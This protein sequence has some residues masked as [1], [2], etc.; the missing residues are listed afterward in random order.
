MTVCRACGWLL[1]GVLD[2]VP[3]LLLD[4]RLA[5][6]KDVRFV[7]HGSFQAD[8]TETA[9]VLP[10]NE[11]AVKARTMLV[12]E[13]NAAVRACALISDTFEA[14]LARR[15][16]RHL[17]VLSRRP[18]GSVWAARISYAAAGAHVAIDRP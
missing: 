14:N 15:L 1:A 10:W 16:R 2:D 3:A 12:Y 4:L 17:P 13:L 11:R 5:E 8:R 7:E 9:A 6:V 18:D